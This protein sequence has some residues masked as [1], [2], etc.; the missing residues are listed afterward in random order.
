MPDRRW[1]DPG[2][3]LNQNRPICPKLGHLVRARKDSPLAKDAVTPNSA[4]QSCGVIVDTRGI[5]IQVML[6]CGVLS[7]VR[8]DQVE[9]IN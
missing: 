4:W 9:V 1:C 6:A 3:E 7:W 8:R 2:S 5:E